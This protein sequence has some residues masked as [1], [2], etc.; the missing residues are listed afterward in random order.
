MST[1]TRLAS[2]GAALCVLVSCSLGINVPSL[3]QQS[4]TLVPG[5]VNP[6]PTVS[7][8]LGTNMAGDFPFPD[9]TNNLVP[10]NEPSGQADANGYPIAGVSATSSTDV[11]WMMPT[12]NYNISY[13]G[14]GTLAV[15]G[16]GSLNNAWTTVGSEHRNVLHIVGTP[17]NF[18]NFLTLTIT[19]GAGQTVTNVHIYVPGIDYDFAGTFYPNLLTI[20]APFR[21]IRFMGWTGTPNSPATLWS[22]RTLPTT[23]GEPANS[24]TPWD[25]VVALINQTG[26]DAWINI[27]EQANDAFVQSFADF[28]RDNLDFSGIQTLRDQAGFTTPFQIYIE[29]SNETWSP[30]NNVNT[31]LLAMA[32]ASPA[33]YT[34]TITGNWGPSWMAESTDTMKAG[35]AEAATL[36]HD[37]QIFIQEFS[38]VSQESVIAPVLSGWAL[39]PAYSAAGL[40]FVAQNY[41]PPSQYIKAIALA[42][43]FGPDDSETATLSTYFQSQNADIQSMISIWE[44]FKSLAAQYGVGVVAYEGGQG[45]TGTTNLAIKELAQVDIRQYQSHLSAF[46]AWK[47]VF[48]ESLFNQFALAAN[49][50]MPLNIG[51]YGFWGAIGSLMENPATCVLNLPTLTG[52]ESWAAVDGFCAKYAACAAQVGQ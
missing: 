36:V 49:P 39:G 11:G 14:T 50:G 43:Y 48:G 40:E 42:P 6:N 5:T 8:F 26:K 20:L 35:Q 51:Q 10:F 16:I 18:G 12:A 27:P 33:I 34:G 37:T 31:I 24:M 32:N 30:A 46:A 21:A 45:A 7:S 9:I 19:N 17:Q 4:T 15:S 3:G 44:S 41:G 1:L 28:M 29:Y 52:T 23:F 25:Y 38:S 22:Q 13:V 47:S 2:F